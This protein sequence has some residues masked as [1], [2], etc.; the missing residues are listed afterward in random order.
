MSRL[1][2][3]YSLKLKRK[4]EIP[5]SIPFPSIQQEDESYFIDCVIKWLYKEKIKANTNRNDIVIV[6][7]RVED[8]LWRPTDFSNIIRKIEFSPILKI[9]S[10]DELLLS[11]F[12]K[13]WSNQI[14]NVSGQYKFIFFLL[15]LIEK[16][17]I[18]FLET[19]SECLNIPKVIG[20]ESHAGEILIIP[21]IIKDLE[22]IINGKEV[23]LVPNLY[24]HL[25][26]KKLFP[27]YDYDPPCGG[28]IGK[29]DREC[30]TFEYLFSKFSSDMFTNHLIDILNSRL[31]VLTDIYKPEKI[32][33]GEQ[34]PEVEIS[35]QSLE[36][37]IIPDHVNEFYKIEKTF[38]EAKYI[39]KKVDGSLHWI[40][41]PKFSLIAFIY[42]LL[43]NG[44]I[45]GK[46]IEKY[47]TQC[48]RAIE[49]RYNIL[50]GQSFEKARIQKQMDRL[51]NYKTFLAYRDIKPVEL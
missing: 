11:A 6:Y 47:R 28:R 14:T 48:K 17:I 31:E 7:H 5:I 32:N 33:K 45:N 1:K 46:K 50:L 24:C 38:V 22:G 21:K 23:Q 13:K 37:I 2:S 43:E 49:E 10:Q 39:S 36:D 42:I 25:G 12:T 41:K 29:T 30:Y 20:V 4:K 34:N 35:I 19:A 18:E 27:I 44:Y 51:K 40:K 9:D 15:K 8:M 26:K 16:N 3:K